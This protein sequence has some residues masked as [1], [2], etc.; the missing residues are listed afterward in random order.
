MSKSRKLFFLSLSII[1][2][3]VTVDQ[4]LK[5]WV[6]T[7]TIGNQPLFS[8]GNWFYLL[9][10]ENPGMAFGL[11][12]GNQIGK[13]LLTFARIILVGGLIFYL[14]YIIKQK[15]ASFFVISILSLIIAGAL[16]NIID[17]LFYGIIFN[18][19]PF[20]LGNVVDMLYFPLFLLPDKVP[21]FGGSYFFPAVFNI[22]DSCVTVGIFLI[23]IFNKRFF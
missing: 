15:K 10:V 8:I 9:F 23:L 18:Y 4:V 19:A 2:F 7:H 20:M 13:L 22:A 12:F 16:G 1:F 21:L 3:F 11:H 17:C 14:I 5:I 6:K